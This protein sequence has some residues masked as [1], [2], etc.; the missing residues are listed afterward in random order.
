M[1]KFQI[2]DNNKNE[3]MLHLVQNVWSTRYQ[4]YIS[5]LISIEQWQH[6]L[7]DLPKQIP[8]Q[9]VHNY[10]LGPRGTNINT[11]PWLAL[12]LN[13][14]PLSPSSQKWMTPM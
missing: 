2:Y 4:L 5:V 13:D 11:R 1:I 8:Q 12:S 9:V 7:L 6:L 14:L 10:Q 3:T